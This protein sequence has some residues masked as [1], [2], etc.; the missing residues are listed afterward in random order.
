MA[1][2]IHGI[3]VIPGGPL[4]GPNVSPQGIKVLNDAIF[5]AAEALAMR[6]P[7][8]RRII[9]I[10]SDG[11]AK[12]NEHS[13][14]ETLNQLLDHGI[15]VFAIGMDQ[16]FLSRRLSMLNSY[17]EQTGGAACFLNGTHAL[18]ECYARATDEAR[19]QYVLGYISSNKPPNQVRIFRE[20]DVKMTRPRLDARYRKGYY[21]YPGQ[22]P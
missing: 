12:G 7:D 15:E 9:L 18:E 13:F 19:N 21:Q 5:T 22:N 8:R 17:A 1:P 2:V 10:I 16:A 6:K 4:P 11:L 14:D 20:I 3:P